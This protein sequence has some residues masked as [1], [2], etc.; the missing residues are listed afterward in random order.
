LT[1]CAPGKRFFWAGICSSLSF[2][3]SIWVGFQCSLLDKK[4]YLNRLWLIMP[5]HDC[6]WHRVM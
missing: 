3:S 1:G 2:V 5:G 4:K 6:C